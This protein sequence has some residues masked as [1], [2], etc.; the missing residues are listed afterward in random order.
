[1]ELN[2]QV[3]GDIAVLR[4][5]ED[6]LDAS[7]SKDFRRDVVTCIESHLRVI[8]DMT[9]VQFV[10]SS[11]CGVLLSCLRDLNGRGGDLKL[12]GISKPVRAL[13]ELVRMHKIFEIYNNV[14]EALHSF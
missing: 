4:L 8:F 12:C 7:N 5:R 2:L 9:E 10:D 6:H 13:F 1:M 14:D 3:F 11:G